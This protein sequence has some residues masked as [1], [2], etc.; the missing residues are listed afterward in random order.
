MCT[1]I[2]EYNY[3]HVKNCQIAFTLF[4]QK[5]KKFR[6]INYNCFSLYS[7]LEMISWNI[8]HAVAAQALKFWW[9]SR[10]VY[11]FGLIFIADLGDLRKWSLLVNLKKWW[12]SSLM[13]LIVSAAPGQMYLKKKRK[14]NSVLIFKPLER[15]QTVIFCCF[16]ASLIWISCN[17]L[18][19][20]L[21][22]IF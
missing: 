11:F 21:F 19:Y 10:G 14:I 9:G 1:V 8:F 18:N 6:E 13:G 7:E 5:R 20:S 16:Y 2:C 17:C 3:F 15:S 4:F 22:R 12:G